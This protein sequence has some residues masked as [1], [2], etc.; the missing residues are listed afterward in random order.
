MAAVSPARLGPDGRTVLWQVT[1]TTG[2]GDPATVA[3]VDRLRDSALPGATANTGATTHVGGPTAAQAD[4]NARLAARLPAIIAT[5]V[6][7]AGLLLLLA[8]RAPVVAVKAAVMNL[9][10][11]AASYGVLTAVFQ[12]GWGRARSASTAPCRYPDTSRC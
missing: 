1:P 9:L 4:L 2:P 11:V 5:V 8:F 12:W 10:S 7:V 6:L 3:L